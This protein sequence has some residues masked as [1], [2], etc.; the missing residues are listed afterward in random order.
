MPI[1]PVCGMEVSREEAAAS[2]TYQRQTWFFCSLE[3]KDA[4]NEDPERYVGEMGEEE[5]AEAA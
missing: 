2:S 5:Q 1:D 3:C 4:F